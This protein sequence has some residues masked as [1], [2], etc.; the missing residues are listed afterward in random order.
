MGHHSDPVRAAALPPAHRRNG[1]NAL[2]T[3]ATDRAST[4]EPNRPHLVL[5]DLSRRAARHELLHRDLSAERELLL[6]EP[7]I[8]PGPAG[9]VCERPALCQP[10]AVVRPVRCLGCGRQLAG[11]AARPLRAERVRFDDQH[12]HGRAHP[13]G[14]GADPDQPH[15]G[16]QHRPDTAGAGQ[17]RDAARQRRAGPCR[18]PQSRGAVRA[19]AHLLPASGGPA[20]RRY[21]APGVGRGRQTGP[22]AER[23]SLPRSDRTHGQ[24]LAPG[25]D[26]SAGKLLARSRCRK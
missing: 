4:V 15:R 22:P 21:G 18:Q 17:H 26:A 10:V 16:A 19:D 24:V 12:Q 3:A 8:V 1:T 23:P 13:G 2:G 11:A 5:R 14:Y 7:R 20:A 6:Q 9:W 25:A